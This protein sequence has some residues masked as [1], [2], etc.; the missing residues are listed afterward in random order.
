MGRGTEGF[1]VNM[2]QNSEELGGFDPKSRSPSVHLRK[3]YNIGPKRR[4][5]HD[6]LFWGGPGGGG[7]VVTK[8]RQEEQK[9][10]SKPVF[11]FL[12]KGEVLGGLGR[13][14]FCI[15]FFFYFFF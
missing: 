11:L 12:F 14:G 10:S 15:Y 9:V 8:I 1:G 7:L 5:C 3:I 2:V 4:T 6:I 13:G